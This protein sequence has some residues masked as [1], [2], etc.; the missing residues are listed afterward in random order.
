MEFLS[1]YL[2]DIWLLHMAFFLLAYAIS[3]GVDLGVGMIS[4]LSSSDAE[5]ELLMGTLKSNWHGNQTWLIILAGML[6]G[7]FP[8]F[9]AI[10]FSAMYIPILIMLFG[11]VIRGVSF[12][13]SGHSKN[14][15]RWLVSFGIGS[16]IAATAQGFALGGLLSGRIHVQ[17][18]A[19]VGGGFDWLDPFAMV[20]TAGVL[21]GY[22]MLGASYLI[23]KTKGKTQEK[24]YRYAF[25]FAV[26]VAAISL[27]VHVWTLIRYPYILRKWTEF[28]YFFYMGG[29]AVLSVAA[30]FLFLISLFRHREKA[31]MIWNALLVVFSFTALSVGFYPYMIPGIEGTSITVSEAATSEDT[32]LFMLVVSAIFV[33]IILAYT[34]YEYWV[35]RGKTAP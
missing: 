15:R 11:L 9:Y 7:A 19:Y 5:R 29:L 21:M 32:L 33:P 23:M 20:V 26:P 4:L 16:L 28:P 12:E 35:F 13:F 18:G 30:F 22:A 8:M 1:P 6:F 34:T 25:R 14:P 27:C 24:S 31:L 2:D 10:V 17:G 3:D